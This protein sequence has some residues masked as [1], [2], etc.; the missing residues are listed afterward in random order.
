[1]KAVHGL[2]G[3]SLAR[4]LTAIIKY[5]GFILAAGMTLAVLTLMFSA[6]LLPSIPASAHAVLQERQ[7]LSTAIGDTTADDTDPAV[8]FSGASYL[9]T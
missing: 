2:G 9:V 6:P 1:M 8:D 7:P 4:Y 5:I 3:L